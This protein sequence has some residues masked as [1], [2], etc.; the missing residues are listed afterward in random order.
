M[1]RKSS[2]QFLLILCRLYNEENSFLHSPF[3]V[4]LYAGT[5]KPASLIM[6]LQQF[7][8]ELNELL[9]NG[10]VIEGLLYFVRIKCFIADTPA[11]ALIKCT[12]GHTVYF[13]CEICVIGGQRWSG[14]TRF[15]GANELPRSDVSFRAQSQP[16]YHQ[17]DVTP[18]INIQSLDMV[19]MYLIDLM[20]L[21][22][23]GII[24][25]L[26]ESWLHS[27]YP[28]V[29]LNK[30]K[31]LL[32]NLMLETLKS[33]VPLD[34]QRKTHLFE[35]IAYWKATRYIF[36]IV[37]WTT[38]STDIL[39]SDFFSSIFYSCLHHF[40]FS[41]H[42]NLQEPMLIMQNCIW[43]NLLSLCLCITAYLL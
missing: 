30:A 28:S 11:R 26:L 8:D 24:K 39:L 42:L 21:S 35:E 29:Q 13:C 12:K 9:G 25:K 23:L 40:V 16:Q 34:F 17:N 2:L 31:K 5:E 43:K 20:H 33:Q 10:I 36:S 18:L 6:F 7:I 38:C 41:V 19:K 32:L 37:R 14:K 27:S 3:S 4:A 1:Y 22:P 15:L